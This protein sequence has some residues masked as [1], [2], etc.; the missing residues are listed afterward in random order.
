MTMQENGGQPDTTK[1]EYT[2]DGKNV[3]IQAPGGVPLVLVKTGSA[4]DASM[5]G[6][7]LH[8]VKK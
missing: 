1:G 6:Q 2:V 7:V 4:L 5:M 8:F 3:T